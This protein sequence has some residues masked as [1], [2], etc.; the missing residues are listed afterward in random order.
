MKL[1]FEANSIFHNK[2]IVFHPR[3]LPEAKCLNFLLQ[4]YLQLAFLDKYASDPLASVFPKNHAQHQIIPVVDSSSVL[5][6]NSWSFEKAHDA[7]HHEFTI[8]STFDS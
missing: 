8:T 4:K 3:L 6:Q 2:Q 5:N 1:T 7:A